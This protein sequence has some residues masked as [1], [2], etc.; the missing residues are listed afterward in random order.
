MVRKLTST[1][2]TLSTKK[3]VSVRGYSSNPL[4]RRKTGFEYYYG[5]VK[6]PNK[7]RYLMGTLR[8]RNL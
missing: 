4:Q 1:H 8:V 7:T 6:E 2:E 5:W 3:L